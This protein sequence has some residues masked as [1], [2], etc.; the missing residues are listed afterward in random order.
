MRNKPL[1]LVI[2]PALVLATGAACNTRD[3]APGTSSALGSPGWGDIDNPGGGG[4]GA[5]G[6]GGQ[7]GGGYG[8]NGGEGGGGGTG[9][10]CTFTQGYW[11]N[12]PSAWPVDQLTLGQTTYTKSELLAIFHTPPAGNGLLALAH[13]LIAAKLNLAAG[14]SG[15]GIDQVIADADALIGALVIPPKGD[16]SL[17]SDKTSE[18]TGKL[19]AFNQ[20]QVGP[21]H[22]GDGAM[23]PP[24]GG[25]PMPPPTTMPPPTMPPPTNPPTTYPPGTL[26]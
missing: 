5:G 20:G 3:I 24:G 26:E 23:P 1:L 25:Y 2:L 13:Q 19:D 22:C 7:G 9:E 14:A 17:S 10:G 15:G 18:L 16:G 6:A 12:H 4:A 8:G 21:G 11:K